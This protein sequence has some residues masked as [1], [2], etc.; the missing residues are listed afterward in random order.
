MAVI[1]RHTPC[2]AGRVGFSLSPAP[3]EADSWAA[4]PGLCARARVTPGALGSDPRTERVEG[5][6]WQEARGQTETLSGRGA[7]W[8]MCP[9]DKEW[10]L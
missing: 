4:G 1:Q 3:P 9:I 8:Y 10:H 7:V 2:H 5:E 6:A